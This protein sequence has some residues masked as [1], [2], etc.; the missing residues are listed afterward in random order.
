MVNFP[1]RRP[2]PTLVARTPTSNGHA[3]M[4][5]PEDAPQ[6][7]NRVKWA[8]RIEWAWRIALLAAFVAQAMYLRALLESFETFLALRR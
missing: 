5:Q 3:T 2:S 6:F 1:L 8:K 7:A 4:Q